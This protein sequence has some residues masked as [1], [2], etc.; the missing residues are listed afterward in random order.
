[1]ATAKGRVCFV[2]GPIGE[3]DSEVR[4]HADWFLEEIVEPVIKELDG[5]E[6]IR[7]DKIAAPGMIDAQVIGHLLE[8]EIVV[9]D[10][11]S[12]NPNAFYEIGLRHMIQKPIIHMQLA[13]DKIPFDVS[14]YRAIKFSRTRPSDIRRAKDDLRSAL[15][16]VLAENYKVDNPVTR[17]R[18]QISL[19]LQASPPEKVLN[20]QLRAL[21]RRVSELE[22]NSASLEDDG[23]GSYLKDALEIK[24]KPMAM[25]QMAIFHT[26][27]RKLFGQ[28][29]SGI[30]SSTTETIA[31]VNVTG[32]VGDDIEQY[33]RSIATQ[34][35]VTAVNLTP[36]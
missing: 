9:A 32:L 13:D 8:S 17:A 33:E 19:E 21:Q 5:F 20:D 26:F 30:R 14:L 18:G 36:F 35:G 3:P 31:N 22:S 7:A 34:L 10:L 2:V 15:K 1:M 27:L 16:A 11:S 29:I 28:R 25:P 12:L 23:D 6:V 24:H 4:I